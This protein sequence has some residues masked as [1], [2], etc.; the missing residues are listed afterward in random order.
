MFVFFKD[1]IFERKR[2]CVRGGGWQ[3]GKER[4]SSRLPTKCGARHGAWSHSPDIK[5]WAQTKS[6]M[7]NQLSHPES[8]IFMFLEIRS[9]TCYSM[10]CDRCL[11]FALQM[12]CGFKMFA[13][14]QLLN[15]LREKLLFLNTIFF[16]W[17][18]WAVGQGWKKKNSKKLQL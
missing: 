2:A 4:I 9:M 7:L 11:I 8:P 3:R 17:T 12:L 16:F 14:Y 15:T 1:F 10:D 18:L 13:F 6:Q 5:M